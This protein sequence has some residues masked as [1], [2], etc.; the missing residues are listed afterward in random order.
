LA[1]FLCKLL[2]FA[3]QRL[4]V[5]ILVRIATVMH[6]P[7]ILPFRIPCWDNLI[8]GHEQTLQ[9]LF[10]EFISPLPFLHDDEGGGAGGVLRKRLAF[11]LSVTFTLISETQSFVA[12]GSPTCTYKCELYT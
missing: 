5:A 1:F 2:E 7:N 3:L 10:G 8:N 6:F 11:N 9:L 4:D 12:R